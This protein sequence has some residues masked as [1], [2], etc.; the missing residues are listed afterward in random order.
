MNTPNLKKWPPNID[1]GL[2]FLL[3]VLLLFFIV[4]RFAESL[5]T[6]RESTR[7]LNCQSNLKQIGLALAIYAEEFQGRLPTDAVNL[8]L[9]GSIRL[10]S[11]DL[12]SAKTWI[13]PSDGRRG[14]GM[15]VDLPR[16]YESLTASIVSYSYVPNQIWHKP[17]DPTAPSIVVLDRIGTATAAG[18]TWPKDSNHMRRTPST[19][20]KGGNI[21]FNDGHVE[22]ATELPSALKDKNG[23][24]IVL[25][26]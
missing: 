12:T 15:G 6:A 2:A 4:V 23:R 26:P 19:K 16:G 7:R 5:G 25:S 22:W 9:L 18:S 13:C 10:L 14:T 17:D 24:E 3:G 1:I 21:L 11:N 8:T 20:T